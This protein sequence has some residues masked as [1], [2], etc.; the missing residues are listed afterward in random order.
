[1]VIQYDVVDL[2]DVVRY[3][4]AGYSPKPVNKIVNHEWFV[5]PV[6]GKLVLRLYVEEP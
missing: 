1:M 6:H 4:V 3:F 5:D 2:D